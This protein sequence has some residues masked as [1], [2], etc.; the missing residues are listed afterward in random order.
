MNNIK[1]VIALFLT[2]SAC[3]ND[4]LIRDFERMKAN[5]TTLGV[6]VLNEGNLSSSNASL[7]YYKPHEKEV[8]N[9]VFYNTNGLP[10][11]DVAQSIALT[12]STAYVVLNNSGKVYVL[13]I[14]TFKYIGKI[15]GLTSPRYM[16]LYS[17]NKA[18]ITD[19]YSKSIQIVNPITFQHLGKISVNNRNSSFY[20]HSTEQMQAVG[21]KLFVS[22]WS[23]DNKIL[24]VDMLTDKLTDSLTVAKQPNSMQ[25]DKSDKLWVLSDGAFEGSPYG[26]ELAALT[27]I[28]TSSLH[29]EKVFT[30][31]NS[32]ASPSK[33]QINE[34]KDTLYF[35]SNNVGE[36]ATDYGVYKMPITAQTLPQIPFIKQNKRLFYGLGID[37]NNSDIYVADAI[38]HSQN[39]FVLR[40]NRQGIAIDSFKVG[41]IPNSFYF[42][43]GNKQK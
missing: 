31:A 28:N 34:T 43:Q 27:C 25:I 33:L 13:N 23:Y 38:D 41:I 21:N 4:D 14:N 10:L 42:K 1:F 29:V 32:K 37:P 17:K 5:E 2:L 16:Y 11:G 24:V 36:I 22:C 39:G 7:S 6:F 12:D 30:F 3:M 19:L 8:L 26:H 18:Y 9:N 40:Y 20:Q 35:I 15:T